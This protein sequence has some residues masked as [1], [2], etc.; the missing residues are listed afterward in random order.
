LRKRNLFREKLKMRDI[1]KER[2]PNAWAALVKKVYADM[3]AKN[4]NVKLKDAMVEA[5]K[6][7]R[8]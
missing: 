3:K 4:P 5:K 7:Y 1:K 6:I 8:K 2:K